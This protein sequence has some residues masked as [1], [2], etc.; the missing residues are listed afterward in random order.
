MNRGERTA[1]YNRLM[2]IEEELGVPRSLSQKQ[3]FSGA[4]KEPHDEP[5][6]D[7]R[8]DHFRRLGHAKCSRVQCDLNA[9]MPV[10]DRLWATSAH[11]EVD[12]SGEA[13]G[14]APG[15]MGNSEVGHLTIGAGHVIYQDV[16]RIT[17]AIETGAFF[18]NEVLLAANGRLPAT[19]ARYTCGA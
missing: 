10:M 16:M 7:R 4:K 12:A 5:S 17:K 8:A 3:A 19:A 13:V 18:R 2:R 14:L 1:K 15:V 9:R 11:T 6:S